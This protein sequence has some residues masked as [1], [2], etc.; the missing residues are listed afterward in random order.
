VAEN[1]MIEGDFIK[2]TREIKRLFEIGKMPA[3]IA[4]AHVQILSMYSWVK[5]Y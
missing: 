2:A 1:H 3:P 4:Q 5:V